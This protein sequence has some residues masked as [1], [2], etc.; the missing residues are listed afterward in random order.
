M[1]RKWLDI[2]ITIVHLIKSEKHSIFQNATC[3]K[4]VFANS[5]MLEN[6]INNHEQLKVI[7]WERC[8]VKTF[9]IKGKPWLFK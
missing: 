3:A 8:N 4:C 6:E 2:S 7:Q 1:L 5:D 9:G